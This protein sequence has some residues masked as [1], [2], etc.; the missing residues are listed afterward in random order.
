[1]RTAKILFKDDHAGY[2]IQ[3]D[4]ESFTFQY[5]DEWFNNVNK[6]AIGL[7]LPKSEKEYHSQYLFPFFYNMLP[8]GAN[9]QAICMHH[10][11][12]PDDFFGLLMTTAK[13]DSIGAIRVLKVESEK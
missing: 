1:M 6:P 11:I 9:K 10:R 12:D 2:L 7:T 4:D 13:H 3:H 5:N 8:E